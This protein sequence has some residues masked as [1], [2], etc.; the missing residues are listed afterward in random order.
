[1]K[2][3]W[4]VLLSLVFVLTLA[5]CG[6]STPSN[7]NTSESTGGEVSGNNQGSE[8]NKQDHIEIRFAWWGN[9]ARSELYNQILDIYEAEN[10]H[11][12]II[13]EAAD[14]GDY[15]QKLATQAASSSLPDVFGVK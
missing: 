15:W 14:W 6:S 2:K 1:M 11:V 10:P 4:G 12:T 8:G 7:T 9:A 3:Y 5:A 13:R